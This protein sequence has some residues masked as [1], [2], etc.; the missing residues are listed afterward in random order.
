[1]LVKILVSQGWSDEVVFC[2]QIQ[3][4]AHRATLT[5]VRRENVEVGLGTHMP[6]SVQGLDIAPIALSSFL[7]H[8]GTYKEFCSAI[9]HPNVVGIHANPSLIHPAP[10]LCGISPEG[11]QRTAKLIQFKLTSPNDT[12]TVLRVQSQ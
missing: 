5:R 7:V 1:M 2:K 3:L 4:Q 11:S 9:P 10:S 8:A 6:G 12:Q